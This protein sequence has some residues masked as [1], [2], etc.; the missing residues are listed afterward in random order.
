MDQVH[1]SIE[2]QERSIGITVSA[3]VTRGIHLTTSPVCIQ[4][5]RS[6]IEILLLHAWRAITSY[7]ANDWSIAAVVTIMCSLS[8]SISVAW[9]LKQGLIS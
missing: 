1:Q 9:N 5:V 2:T 3:M 8:W 7:A 4:I 6:A